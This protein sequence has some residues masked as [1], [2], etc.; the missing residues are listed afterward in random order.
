M[1]TTVDLPDELLREAKALAASRGET[2]RELFSVALEDHLNQVPRAARGVH[3]RSG[4]RAAFG[5][6]RKNETDAVDQIIAGECEAI[7]PAEWE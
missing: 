3:R 7:D 5:L 4:W 2:L 1:K 6:A